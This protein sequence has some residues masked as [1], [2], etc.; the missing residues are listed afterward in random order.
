[1]KRGWL[2]AA[3]AGHMLAV[4]AHQG[5]AQTGVPAKPDLAKAQQIVTQVWRTC[6]WRG[7]ET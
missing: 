3:V 1:M 2:L 4:A 5:I 6:R 7:L